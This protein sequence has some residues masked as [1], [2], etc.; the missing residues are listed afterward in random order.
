MKSVQ[1]ALIFQRT[2][3]GKECAAGTC[4]ANLAPEIASMTT[5]T[6]SDTRLSSAHSD[7]GDQQLTT[8]AA[9]QSIAVVMMSS[10]SA[11]DDDALQ[12]LQ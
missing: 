3:A 5:A 10:S 9:V 11:R 1:F 2:S 7:D 6:G 8:S 12:L 4:E